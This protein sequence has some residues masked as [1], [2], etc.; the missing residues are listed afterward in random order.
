MG[1]VGVFVVYRPLKIVG[2]L[3]L[4]MLKYVVCLCNTEEAYSRAGFMNLL[5]TPSCC[6]ECFYIITKVYSIISP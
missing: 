3:S 1:Y 5:F 2:V 6:G 4:G